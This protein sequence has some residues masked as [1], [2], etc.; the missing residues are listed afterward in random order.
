MYEY[1]YVDLEL[2]LSGWGPV[3]GIQ[4]DLDC[5]KEVIDEMAKMGWR[6]VTYLPSRQTKEG[7]LRKV[8]LVFERLIEEE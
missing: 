1:E 6:F 5:F 2:E 3:H 8:T 4:Y 7:A